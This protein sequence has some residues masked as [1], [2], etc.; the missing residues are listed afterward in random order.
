MYFNTIILNENQL[1]FS[2]SEILNILILLILCKIIILKND[3]S[4]IFYIIFLKILNL[5]RN[6]RLIY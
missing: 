2:L 5:S 4:N 6:Y 3:F 1:S